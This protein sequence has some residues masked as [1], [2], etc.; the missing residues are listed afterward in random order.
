MARTIQEIQSQIIDKIASTRELQALNNIS[1]TSIYRLFVYVVAVCQWTLDQLFDLHKQEVNDLISR[2][3][4]HSM[5]WYAEK[6]KLFQYGFNLKQES[7][8]YDNTNATT[9]EITASRVVNLCAIVEQTDGRGVLALRVKA[10]SNQGNLKKLTPD[11]L[12][13][14]TTYM[15]TVKDAGVRLLVSSDPADNLRLKINIYYNP[16]VLDGN[17]SRLDGNGPNPV[18]A[19]IKNY[20]TQLPFN[21]WL[22]LTYLTDALQQVDGVVIPQILQAEARY[23]SLPFKAFD[24]MYQPDAGYLSIDEEHDLDIHYIPQSTII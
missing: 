17:G 14:F 8:E 21:G 7:D 2:M 16:L 23:G 20:L 6:A 3:K 5:K 13:S 9:E 15:N 24:V 4:P 11:Q 18:V 22:V 1:N 12:L 19:A 10:A